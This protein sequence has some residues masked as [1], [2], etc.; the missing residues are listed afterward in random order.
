MKLRYK[1]SEKDY[2]ALLA[3]LIRKK[4]AAPWRRVMFFVLTA[5][6]MA[7]VAW[8][9]IF[10]LAPGQRLFYIVWSL[11][12]AGFTLLRRFTAPARAKGT[13]YRLKEGGQLPAD[14]WEEHR[15]S[16]E[17][18]GLVLCYGGVRTVCP[19]G[20]FSGFYEEDGLLYLKAGDGI[21]D[22][23]PLETFSG[24]EKKEHFLSALR[25]FQEKQA[26]AAAR[27]LREESLEAASSP[28]LG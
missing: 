26:E 24:P 3:G 14:F 25:A 12:L 15:L 19:R 20:S 11:L 23:I 10:R 9:C 7:V 28:S 17:E 8:L 2:V 16:E 13:L 6:Q 21:F 1:V 5:G 27:D 22:I 18:E 4:D